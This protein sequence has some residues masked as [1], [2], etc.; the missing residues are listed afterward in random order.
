MNYKDIKGIKIKLLAKMDKYF[1]KKIYVE[2]SKDYQFKSIQEF[3][4]ESE[5]L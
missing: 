3:Y 1:Y 2:T 5:N 4:T